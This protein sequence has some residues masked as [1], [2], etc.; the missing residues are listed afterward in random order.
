MSSSGSFFEVSLSLYLL[1]ALSL[2]TA[3]SLDCFLL[4]LVFLMFIL[5]LSLFIF[6][7]LWIY[8]YIYI[9]VYLY[10]YIGLR[11]MERVLHGE[12]QGGR[13]GRAWR[14]RLAEKTGGTKRPGHGFQPMAQT[15]THRS[16]TTTVGSLLRCVH[17]IQIKLRGHQGRQDLLW[18]ASIRIG[19]AW[20]RPESRE[21][22]VQFA[23]WWHHLSHTNTHCNI[24]IAL[25]VRVAS[26]RYARAPP[27]RHVYTVGKKQ[28]L[29][30]TIGMFWG[31]NKLECPLHYWLV[32]CERHERRVGLGRLHEYVT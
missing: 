11:T 4:V 25:G 20:L 21:R 2:S 14:I 24:Q 18:C 32:R 22:R 1:L 9:Y 12:T 17:T 7:S 26:K 29:C 16:E 3:L 30:S 8:I 15:K 6:L 31:N 13:T 23:L 19:L 10:I 28:Y 27:L 5:F